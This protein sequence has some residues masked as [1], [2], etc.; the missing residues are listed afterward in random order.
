M[1]AAAMAQQA[2]EVRDVAGDSELAAFDQ[3]K[4]D[5]ICKHLDELSSYW[6]KLEV[7]QSMSVR[8]PDLAIL[9]AE[10]PAQ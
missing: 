2:K 5:E 4:L 3:R 9:P 10:P 6:S 8:W 7:G 1:T